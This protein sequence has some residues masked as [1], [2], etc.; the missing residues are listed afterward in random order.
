[1]IQNYNPRPEVIVVQCVADLESAEDARRRSALQWFAQNPTDPQLRGQV[2]RALNRSLDS[3]KNLRDS[4]LARALDLWGTS[5]NVPKMLK[6]LNDPEPISRMAARKFFQIQNTAAGMLV[7]QCIMDLDSLEDQR[8]RNALQW[9]AQTPADPQRRGEVAKALNKLIE[10]DGSFN[11]PDLGKSLEN[12]G[13]PENAPKL[14]LIL[15]QSRAGRGDVIRALGK[16]RDPNGIKAVA[17]RIGNFFDRNEVQ[18]VLREIGPAAEP[19]VVEVMNATMDKNTRTECAR[20]LGEIGTKAGSLPSLQAL[21]ARFQQ[22]PV[23][24]QDR[25]FMMTA[26]ASVQAITQ[27]GK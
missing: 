18:K 8:R 4:D 15:D 27:R 17:N 16:I 14:I 22:L 26:T 12:W 19:V 3:E 10:N 13:T 9:F 23:F 11:N 21:Y 6:F 7:G 24:Q 20:L 5:E 1:V 25:M 2:A